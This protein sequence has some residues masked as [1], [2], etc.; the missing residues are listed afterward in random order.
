M[1]DGRPKVLIQ[2]I[3][4][5]YIGQIKYIKGAQWIQRTRGERIGVLVALNANQIGWSVVYGSLNG[6]TPSD[7]K[8]KKSDIN[9]DI[10]IEKAIERAK[11]PVEIAPPL[12]IKD[13]IRRF[14]IRIAKI[15]DW[16]KIVL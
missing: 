5:G 14:K 13:D 8:E 6:N 2:Y 16:S 9:W 11:S 7:K 3:R 1:A 15:K 10:G 12:S 4:R